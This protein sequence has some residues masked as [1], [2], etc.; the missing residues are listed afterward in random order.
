VL[1]AQ[2]ECVS[3]VLIACFLC[4]FVCLLV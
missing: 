4:E 1:M 3:F 2:K